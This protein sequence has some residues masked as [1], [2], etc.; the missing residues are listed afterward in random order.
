LKKI[1]LAVLVIW[2]ASGIACFWSVSNLSFFPSWAGT[3]GEFKDYPYDWSSHVKMFSSFMQGERGY[4][5]EGYPLFL[6]YFYSPDLFLMTLFHAL[7]VIPLLVFAY[8]KSVGLSDEQAFFTLFIF[9]ASAWSLSAVV[10]GF[11]KQIIVSEFL[12]LLLI[13]Y[14]YVKDEKKRFAFIFLGAVAGLVFEPLPRLLN[15]LRFQ[16]SW[17]FKNIPFNALP[18]VFLLV[19]GMLGV[20]REKKWLV[21]AV[22]V[23]FSVLGS[24]ESRF[25]SLVFL[26]LLPFITVSFFDFFKV[27]KRSWS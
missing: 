5:S 21:G 12:L 24:A 10:I 11:L 20:I 23:V 3:P 2:I 13:S 1:T 16:A 14:H 15:S 19:P 9:F 22:S 4:N 18:G 27:I 25:F 6:Y 26:T 7:I 17:L 8:S